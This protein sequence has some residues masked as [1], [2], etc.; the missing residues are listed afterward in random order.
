MTPHFQDEI[1]DLLNQTPRPS[2]SKFT[3]N[4]DPNTLLNR[5]SDILQKPSVEGLYFLIG[6][7]RVSG[8]K[9]LW[10]LLCPRDNPRKI[11]QFKNIKLLVGIEADKFAKHA[12]EAAS[13]PHNQ[14]LANSLLTAYK[15]AFFAQQSEDLNN[16]EYAEFVEE[17]F[18]SLID[19]LKSQ[20]LQIR[21]VK[22]HSTH[23]KFYIF[24][25]KPL[26]SKSSDSPHFNGTLFVGSSNLSESGLQK[27]YEFNLESQQRDDVHFALCE[28]KG[29]W[30]EAVPLLEE[31]DVTRQVEEIESKIKEQSYLKEC[32]AEEIY[33]KLLM[34]Y[35]SESRIKI[36]NSLRGLFPS[37]FK[38]PDYQLAAISEGLEKLE[39][40]NGFFLSD[41]VG[42]GK[43]LIASIIAKKLEMQNEDFKAIVI[44]PAALKA[45]WENHFELVKL[46]HRKVVSYD[47]L[48]K[49]QKRAAEYDFVIIDESHNLSST[50]SDRF[51]ETQEFCKIPTRKGERKKVALLSAT[52]QRNSP[53]DILSQICLFQDKTNSHIESITNLEKTFK[54]WIGS[55]ESLKSL[56][57]KSFEENDSKLNKECSQK[58]QEI[59][60]EIRDKL[61][62]FVM[63]RRT[64]TDIEQTETFAQNLKEL[65]ITFPK[66]TPPQEL[67][68]SFEPKTKN[69]V[70]DT[71][72]ALNPELREFGK[73]G[74][75]SYARY[76]IY[77]NLTPSGQVKFDKAYGNKE[78]SQR[79]FKTAE[80]L[81]GLIQTLL[82]KRLESSFCAFKSTLRV[83]IQSYEAFLKMFKEGRV[84]V[85]KQLADRYKFY[86]DV[87]EDEGLLDDY[88][89]KGKAFELAPEDFVP[90]YEDKLQSDLQTLKN[91]LASYEKVKKDAK[92][93]KLLEQLKIFG[94]KK[95]VIF[96]EATTT[97]DYL[98]ERLEKVFGSKVININASNRD[99][100]ADELKANFDANF[101]TKDQEDSLQILVT[102]D[103]LAE[104]V[105][106]HR[107]NIIINY[108]SP[109]SATRLMQRLGRINRIGTKFE[110]IYIYNFKPSDIGDT[111]LN[112]NATA[113]Q[114]LQSF[115]FTFGEDS[116]IYDI[117]EEVGTQQLFRL[118][119]QEDK[120]ADPQTPFLNDIKKLYHN[121]REEFERLKAL[122]PKSR[123][124]ITS[125]QTTLCYIKNTAGNN[126]FY[127]YENGVTQSDFVKVASYLKSK[128]NSKTLAPRQ[129]QLASHYNAVKQIL[130][131]HEGHGQFEESNQTLFESGL[132]AEKSSNQKVQTARNKI[133]HLPPHFGL[134]EEQRELIVLVLDNGTLHKLATNITNAKTPEDYQEIWQ[135]CKKVGS[136]NQAQRLTPADLKPQIQLLLSSFN[137][138][139][140]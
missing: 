47:L 106:L 138:D 10:S 113:Y 36:D 16:A 116:A 25:E 31:G 135:I 24:A 66:I 109:W 125:P 134:D 68:Y 136:Q 103:T 73:F 137:K 51:N 80:S 82:F 77:P 7:F 114:K 2:S 70:F 9:Q 57:K 78:G 118:V 104:G 124:F 3:N 38:Q 93:E 18:A 123:A 86:D 110:S 74:A 107:S 94:D 85:P 52:P 26:P 71:I 15:N 6:F 129:S 65:G 108:D 90:G 42:L 76:L 95:V 128:L 19:A 13:N 105:N 119:T 46:N 96:T 58:L 130:R 117:N 55:F 126:F 131:F 28:F 122:K 100:K 139:A 43:T 29:L 35:F 59:S 54:P 98:Y 101:P 44:C 33:Y 11:E 1:F 72:Y 8:F 81:K 89:S 27:N 64:R 140:K 69:I 60:N 5:F 121:N 112:Y 56:L 63:V 91:M 92:F 115:H 99:A 75:L 49:E 132:T 39:K 61:L 34:E 20:K 48:K 83:Q 102:T 17:S 62:R 79:S 22:N 23:A 133:L 53:K 97:A 12:S 14:E 40:Y 4:T 127:T 88:I 111:I 37:G 87:L 30:E 32:S 21:I 50:D 45:N 41:V 67:L 120:D 84:T